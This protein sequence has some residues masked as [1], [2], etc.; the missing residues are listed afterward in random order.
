MTNTTIFKSVFFNAPRDVIWSY[1]TDKDKLGIWYHPAESDLKA[2]SD[3]TLIGQNEDGTSK[4]QVWGHVLEMNKPS[5]LVT[6]F[7][8]PPFQGVETTVTWILEEAAGGTRLS[9]THEG[10]AEAGG[11]A[12]MHLLMALDDGWD[13]HLGRLRESA[14]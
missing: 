9:L 8:I 5:K 13:R 11:T 4:P 14:K 10:I 6:T 1:L 2:G 3:Y 7:N 12:A